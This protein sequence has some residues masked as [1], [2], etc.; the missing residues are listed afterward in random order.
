MSEGVAKTILILAGTAGLALCL[1]LYRPSFLA[2]PSITLALIGLEIVLVALI[3]FRD[4]FFPLM[5][6]TFIAAGTSMPFHAALLAARW[7]VLGIGAAVG[8]AVYLK[9]RAHYFSSF[10]LIA[11]SCAASAFVSAYVSHYRAESLLKALSLFLLFTYCGSGVRAAVSALTPEVFFRRLVIGCEVLTVI[12]AIAYLMFRWAMFGNPNSLGA[13][14]SVIVIPVL[15]WA[16]LT[17]SNPGPRLRLGVEL[18][19]ALVLL[20]SSFARASIVAA[21]FSCLLVCVTL[22]QYRLLIKGIAFSI[23]LAAIVGMFLPNLNTE[24]D[25]EQ[26]Q[27][28]SS[29]F[30]YKGHEERG[31]FDSRKS[32]WQQTWSVIEGNPWFGSGFGTSFVSGDM[33]KIDYRARHIDS[34]VIREHGN[35]YLAIAEW[36][37]LLGVI[38]FYLLALLAAVNAGKVFSWLRN[39]EDFLS[40]ALPAAAIVA[41]GLIHAIFEDWMFAS[42]YYICLFFWAMAFVLADLRPRPVSAYTP[43]SLAAIGGQPF[44]VA[45]SVR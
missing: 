19:L 10:H 32:V 43:E 37:G 18:T 38:P 35:S 2:D 29:R 14:T 13:I 16:F 28:M 3:R 20:L 8:I 15:L 45:A 7:Y 5:M 9:D 21:A 31:V 23:I 4:A 24:E 44:T 26:P 42:G 17:A 40:P 34:W 22:R 36:T 1:L 39:T 27:S 25:D 12:S 41:S 33:T 6:L 11:V 30:L